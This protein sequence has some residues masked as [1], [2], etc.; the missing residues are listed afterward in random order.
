[1]RVPALLRTALFFLVLAGVLLGLRRDASAADFYEDMRKWSA[2]NWYEKTLPKRYQTR[3]KQAELRAY[4][5]TVPMHLAEFVHIIDPIFGGGVSFEKQLV[6][7]RGLA[8]YIEANPT[9]RNISIA[10]QDAGLAFPASPGGA[11]KFFIS[12]TGQVIT[13]DGNGRL[14]A[15]KTAIAMTEHIWSQ[16][17][18]AGPFLLEG[19]A[20]DHT[21]VPEGT[22]EMINAARR[23][24]GAV[25]FDPVSGAFQKQVPTEIQTYPDG[26]MRALTV[27]SGM[28][29]YLY[30][31][32]EQIL[33]R[34]AIKAA[35]RAGIIEPTPLEI[36][37]HRASVEGGVDHR[38]LSAAHLDA[39]RAE[40]ST[41]ARK[42]GLSRQQIVQD[43]Q[44]F[45]L[46][47]R[48]QPRTARGR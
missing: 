47:R 33:E 28:D 35:Q 19:T 48:G 17:P 26:P 41:Y 25:G 32:G 3:L 43:L 34:N 24:R 38:G 1:M 16:H 36:A 39:L 21:M 22:A 46:S 20:I 9:F 30:A 10:F 31:L 27:E 6:R 40:Y 45:G 23:V 18:E 42:E 12:E 7:Q 15:Y 4:T 11:A 44:Y 5:R 29:A 37:R 8:A 2:E 14:Y 13:Y